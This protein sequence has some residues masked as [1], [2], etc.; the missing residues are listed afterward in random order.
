MS[1]D[2]TIGEYLDELRD[3]IQV[4]LI[5]LARVGNPDTLQL[6]C[7]AIGMRVADP[8]NLRSLI[9]PP[10]AHVDHDAQK[11]LA[12]VDTLF[13]EEIAEIRDV[14]ADAQ[15]DPAWHASIQEGKQQGEI[16]ADQD[17]LEVIAQTILLLFVGFDDEAPARDPER[18]KH[19]ED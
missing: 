10:P 11:I 4:K 2:R 6:I 14:I 12:S 18:Q 19:G 5:R 1:D 3:H 16:P 9:A 8:D 7:L 13:A 17:P 15:E